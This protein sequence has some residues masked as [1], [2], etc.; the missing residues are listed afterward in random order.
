MEY[1][2][3]PIN[4]GSI[5]LINI[6]LFFKRMELIKKLEGFLC[7]TYISF[8]ILQCNIIFFLTVLVCLLIIFS[9]LIIFLE[10]VNVLAI[11]RLFHKVSFGTRKILMKEKKFQKKIKFSCLVSPKT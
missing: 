6:T 4:Y 10:N 3:E 7:M 2:H 11:F 9:V 1:E 8:C 5:I